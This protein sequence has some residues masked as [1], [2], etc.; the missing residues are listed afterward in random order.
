LRK[1][2]DS[3]GGWGIDRRRSAAP[4]VYWQREREG[5][6]MSAGFVA[7]G[8]RA[9]VLGFNR[10]AHTEI[11]ERP[12]VF[13]GVFGPVPVAERTRSDVESALAFLVP[14]YR[15]NGLGSLDFVPGPDGVP[16]VL[17]VNAR[18][19]ASAALYPWLDGASP[20][21]AHLLACTTGE[22]PE[23]PAPTHVRGTR[24]VFARR[25]LRLGEAEAARIAATPAASDLPRPGTS[26][27]AGEPVCTLDAEGTDADAVEAA[28]GATAADLLHTLEMA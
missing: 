20:L 22:L 25:P 26:F 13:E 19:S 9:V 21:T 16:E 27:A 28:L 12:F 17:E 4:G 7:N 3:A 10:Q 24:I 1:R 2:T 18:P 6:P 5:V 14:A 23:V 8:E 15:L 11:G